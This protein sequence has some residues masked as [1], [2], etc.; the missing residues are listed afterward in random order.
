MADFVQPTC[1]K[2]GTLLTRSSDSTVWCCPK[3][4]TVLGLLGQSSDLTGCP[5]EGAGKRTL[6]ISD[7]ERTVVRPGPE[8]LNSDWHSN[9]TVDFVPSSE[10]TERTSSGN[11]EF[12]AP[13]LKEIAR[14]QVTDVL[15]CG[16]F[17]TVYR[18]F[19]PLL[20]REVA[21]KVPR[22]A[23]DDGGMMERFHREA[24]AA[25][26]LHHPNIVALHESGQTDDGPYL[27]T[28]FI[29]G[30]PLSRTLNGKPLEISTAVD[31]VRQ[32]AEGLYYAHCEGIVHRDVKPGNVMISRSG[33][34]Q[35]MDFGLAKR[36]ADLESEM[37]VE[38]QIV[39]TPSYMSPEQARGA[40]AEIG[41]RSD[42]YSVGVILYELLCGQPPF[43][44][45]PWTVI[46]RVAN[47]NDVPPSPRSL[48][49]EISRD[50]EAC[51]LKAMEKDPRARYAT[52]QALA[53]DLDHWMRGLP[54][55]ARP[56][57]PMEQLARW[58]RQNR[59]IAGL[60]GAVVTMILAAAIIGSWL[61]I[62]F[63]DLATIAER[64]ARD[65]KVARK[66]EE[67]ARNDTEKALARE[68]IARLSTERSVVDSYTE[69]GLTAHRNNDPHEAILW[70]ANAVAESGNYP[71]RERDNRIRLQSWLSQVATPVRAFRPKN[72]WKSVLSYHS[73]G[74]WLLSLGS[75]GECELLQVSSGT[76][77][78]LP[79]SG[80]VNAAAFSPD[81]NHMVVASDTTLTHFAV[82]HE[83]IN[84]KLP[85]ENGK[86]N[87][88]G[89][90]TTEVERWNHPDIVRSVTF[91]ENSLWLLVSGQNTV[92][93]RDV[94]Q[95]SFRSNAL[96]LDSEVLSAAITSNGRRFS[97]RC[98]DQTARLF[99]IAPDTGTAE[100][101][102]PPQPSVATGDLAPLFVGDDRWIVSNDYKSVNCWD[103]D[104]KKVVWEHKPS[105]VL[106]NAKSR[107][108]KWIA[109]GEDSEVVLLDSVT[110]EQATERIK[111]SNLLNN[112]RF[113][114]DG[115][116]LMTA[117]IDHTAHLYDVSTGRPIGPAI[118]HCD[119]VHRCE[120]SPDGKSFATVHWTGGLV[121]VW[122][123]SEP[124]SQKIAKS[125]PADGPFVRFNVTGD[126]WFSCGFDGWRDR[127]TLEIFDLNSG[128]PVGP[129]LSMPE[130]LSDADFIPKSP[131][132]VMVGGSSHDEIGRSLK[133][134]K[135]EQPGIIRF[136][137]SET[138]QPSWDAV[139]TSSQPIAVRSSPD[140][141]TIVVLCFQ[142]EVALLNAA[143]GQRRA[144]LTAFESNPAVFGFVIRDR[145]RF[146]E[147]GDLFALW[148]CNAHAELRKT[149]T[150]ELVARVSHDS[151]FIH[152]VQFS[153]DGRLMATCSSD[154]T[155]RL[156][157]TA[158]GQLSGPPLPHSGW[159]FNAQFS[160]DGKRLLTAS[161]DRQAR[162]WDV[163]THTA[164]LATREHSDQ[165]FG[166]SFLPDEEMFLA[167]TRDGQITAWSSSLGK[168]LAPAKP[169]GGMVYQLTRPHT[170]PLVVASGGMESVRSF[171]WREWILDPDTQLSRSDARLLGEIFSSKRVHEGGA[172]TRLTSAEWLDRWDTFRLKHPKHPMFD[173]TPSTRLSI[174]Q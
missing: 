130:L 102:M 166:I 1:Q 50:L 160:R 19:D 72:S 142:G 143:T 123:P 26:R 51:C 135:L 7:S 94:I 167:A 11:R 110:G 60:I 106:T 28:E 98:G 81:G 136:M 82:E 95:K 93:V 6:S 83:T 147:P 92:Q 41:P 140:G 100:L 132:I 42:Q 171:D 4:K 17:G 155:L 173:L 139:T 24:K 84:Q 149:N 153:P 109:L 23:N 141:Q 78:P 56:I 97:V 13:T 154:H 157:E 138:G 22:F 121:R 165:V 61:A 40:I 52:L 55:L 31:W 8:E 137:N 170:S 43:V 15:G 161:S 65:A 5:P 172:A 89:F 10:S 30:E 104:R 88:I 70:F 63:E 38:G 86:E 3:C 79:F 119:S 145:I 27:V 150:G 117:C 25:A 14:F 125:H 169:L 152:D 9:K 80:F 129:E 151:G 39:G 54:L 77:H 115:S 29:D 74:Q 134:Q 114:P 45:E 21:L 159:V 58:C 20:D 128:K 144:Q 71:S 35:L 148:G 131:L 108:D 122:K 62:R 32:I 96:T 16:S 34:P 163:A 116:K 90:R 126:R 105:R 120:W 133:S 168:M 158:N 85:P 112:I 174:E 76:S 59:A 118:P 49:P 47:V 18:A 48:R 156:W 87:L 162:I 113:H 103:V 64:E 73:S 2:C 124:E 75:T 37:T 146:S 57:G 107:D 99:S 36:D 127:T 33:R 46:A 69:S 111:H 53:D 12:R 91:S 101:E 67:K 68:Q 164:V 44:G 66:E